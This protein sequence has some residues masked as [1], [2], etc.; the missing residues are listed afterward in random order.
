ML[1]STKTLPTGAHLLYVYVK[2]PE[3]AEMEPKQYT[4]C[5]VKKG[6]FEK[7]K[8]SMKTYRSSMPGEG[9]QHHD[10]REQHTQIALGE[11]HAVI[12]SS[13]LRGNSKLGEVVS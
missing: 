8:V 9:G 5:D 12:G 11:Q 10:H 1:H 6:I 4:L 13:M 2:A 7:K 3:T